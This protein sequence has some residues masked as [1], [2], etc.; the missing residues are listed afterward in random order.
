ML[1]RHPDLN[2][3]IAMAGMMRVEDWHRPESFPAVRTALLPGQETADFAMPLDEF[4]DQAR[5][6][7]KPS[8]RQ[9]KSLSIG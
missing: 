8:R 3:L 2:V 4:V 6:C 7:W 1:E 5:N 9:R